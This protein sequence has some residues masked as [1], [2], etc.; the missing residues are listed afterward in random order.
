MGME[1]DITQR[2]K[3]TIDPNVQFFAVDHL[4]EDLRRIVE[5]YAKLAEHVMS[6]PRNPQRELALQLL[7]Q[8]KDAAVRA[9]VYKG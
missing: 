3:P 8:S 4:R 1:N 9:F 5:P 2:E 7:I 6:L